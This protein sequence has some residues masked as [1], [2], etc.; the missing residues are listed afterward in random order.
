MNIF[1]ISVLMESITHENVQFCA[2]DCGKNAIPL[3]TGVWFKI[4]MKSLKYSISI[5]IKMHT[6]TCIWHPP[7]TCCSWRWCG[8]ISWNKNRVCG[9]CPVIQLVMSAVSWSNDR[10]E[11]QTVNTWYS[12]SDD[13]AIL[14]HDQ[15]TL[16]RCLLMALEF[17]LFFGWIRCEYSRIILRDCPA[18][19]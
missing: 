1:F 14:S 11:T 5:S 10:R 4:V 19:T 8:R 3:W 7:E 13:H 12:A 15:L 9:S 2:E 6:N 16:T 18:G 17:I